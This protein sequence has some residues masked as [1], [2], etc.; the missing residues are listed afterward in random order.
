MLA[1]LHR[2]QKV[3]LHRFTAVASLSFFGET[4]R[5]I[6]FS[7]L[8]TGLHPCLFAK[9]GEKKKQLEKTKTIS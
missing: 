7:H 6:P 2:P 4:R 9:A 5:S 1:R 8:S 3:K